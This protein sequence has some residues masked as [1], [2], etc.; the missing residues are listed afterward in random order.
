MRAVSASIL[1]VKQLTINFGGLIAVNNL[2]MQ[3]GYGEAVGLIGPNGAGK[4]SAFNLISGVYKPTH[5][6]VIFN[7]EDITGLPPHVINRKG[8]G[9]TFQIVKPFGSMTVLENVMVGGFAHTSNRNKSKAIAMEVIERVGLQRKVNALAK[10]LT[11]ADR[12]RLEV[13]KALATDPKLLLLDE[14]LAGLNPTEVEEAVDMIKDINKSGISIL[15]I[16]HVLQAT[17]AICNHIVVLD[18][19]KKIA[20]G[21]PQEVTNN[22]EVIKAYLGDEYEAVIN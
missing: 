2:D 22:P 21:T 18:Y 7:G 6:Q 14:V 4:T 17:M 9:R 8:I 10:S 13:A 1:E 11:L 3:V 15:M 16:E 19:G 20:E 12:K 5:G